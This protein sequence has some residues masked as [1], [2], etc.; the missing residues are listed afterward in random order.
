MV[1]GGAFGHT[2]KQSIAFAYVEPPYA[3][4]GRRFGI[5]VLGERR[6]ATVLPGPLYDPLN[7]KLRG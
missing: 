2:V 6:A 5:D 7:E 3:E 1:T 4:P